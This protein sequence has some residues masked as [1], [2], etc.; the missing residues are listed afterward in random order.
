MTDERKIKLYGN[1]LDYVVD[2]VNDDSEIVRVLLRQGFE[3]DEINEELELNEAS[4]VIGLCTFPDEDEQFCK[5]FYVQKGWLVERLETLDS[6][7]ERKGVDLDR[8]IENYIWDETWFLYEQAKKE[9][10]ML[11]EVVQ[12]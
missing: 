11:Y 9:N 10:V 4:Q 8:F 5:V 6:F 3:P 12:L 1:L 7:N 2:V